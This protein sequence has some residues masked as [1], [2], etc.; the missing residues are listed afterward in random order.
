MKNKYLQLILTKFT[1]I[2][3]GIFVCSISFSQAAISIDS[4]IKFD[5]FY[6]YN[7][8]PFSGLG[9][10]IVENKIVESYTYKN[11]L[12]DGPYYKL[13]PNGVIQEKGVYKPKLL[14]S[15]EW[16]S[17]GDGLKLTFYENGNISGEYTLSDSKTIGVSKSYYPNGNLRTK[18]NWN[19][20]GNYTGLFEEYYENGQLRSKK[21]YIKSKLNGPSES[22]WENGVL[23]SKE[24]Y[25]NDQVHG[26]SLV[27]YTN[28]NLRDSSTYEMGKKTGKSVQY[29]ENG[30]IRMIGN[31][32]LFQDGS[33]PMLPQLHGEYVEYYQNGIIKEKGTYLMGRREGVH[34]TYYENGMIHEKTTYKNDSKNR[35][36]QIKG[37]WKNGLYEKYDSTGKLLVS[38]NYSN[39]KFVL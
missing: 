34:Y 19:Q 2:I 4:L 32:K 22:Y 21:T 13:Y 6:F 27:Y 1:L 7:G 26:L 36:L 23:S 15:G 20:E 17:L 12:Q 11:G 18:K 31:Y 29:F 37:D 33:N 39:G 14:N 28:G 35:M 16:V 8:R 25:V 38:G 3:L 5:K 10:K 30:N 9:N 24:I